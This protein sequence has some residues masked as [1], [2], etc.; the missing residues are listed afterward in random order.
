MGVHSFLPGIFLTQGLNLGLP[1]Y[2]QILYILSYQGSP[3]QQMV[4]K[5]IN[6]FGAKIKSLA[7]PRKQ[8]SG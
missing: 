8:A 1:H 3:R 2:R 6:G 7:L 5:V 4:L